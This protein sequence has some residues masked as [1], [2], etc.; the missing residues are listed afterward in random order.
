MISAGGELGVAHHRD[1][2]GLVEQ[3]LLVRGQRLERRLRVVEPV[4]LLLLL[5]AVGFELPRC[6]SSCAE[7]FES[8]EI[9]VPSVCVAD[10]AYFFPALMSCDALDVDD[11]GLRASA[12]R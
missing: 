8:V 1:R 10:S 12:C 6:V 3:L 11:R 5:G 4:L 2:A 9:F 7:R